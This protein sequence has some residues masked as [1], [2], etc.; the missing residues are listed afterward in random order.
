MCNFYYILICFNV[1]I[2][3]SYCAN[4][5]QFDII[6]NTLQLYYEINDFEFT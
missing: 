2:A 4:E 1:G 3:L 5:N 6:I